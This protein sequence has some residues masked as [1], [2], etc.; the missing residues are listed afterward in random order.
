MLVLAPNHA[1]RLTLRQMQ[2]VVVEK[3]PNPWNPADATAKA[4]RRPSRGTAQVLDKKSNSHTI[5]LKPQGHALQRK[6]GAGQRDGTG[7]MNP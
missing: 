1:D 2:T 5:S 6:K 4:A 7:K 3:R